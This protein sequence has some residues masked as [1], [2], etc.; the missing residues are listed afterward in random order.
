MNPV[1]M[2]ENTNTRTDDRLPVLVI[3]RY[4]TK[5]S[6]Y[7][8]FNYNLIYVT[9]QL[10]FSA[11]LVHSKF[12]KIQLVI[13]NLI[14]KINTTITPPMIEKMTGNE[15]LIASAIKYVRPF[16]PKKLK[17][18]ML[19]QRL[20]NNEYINASAPCFAG[21]SVKELFYCEDHFRDAMEKL[22]KTEEE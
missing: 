10:L 22:E 5:Y 18:Y 3:G 16:G 20:A 1:S 7:S 17:T 21:T 12:T 11:N 2:N 9:Y 14:Q 15:T 6:Y 8:S 4:E 19:K 13:T